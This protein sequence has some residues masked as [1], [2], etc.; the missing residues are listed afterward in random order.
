MK[1]CLIGCL[2]ACAVCL[3][4]F[5]QSKTEQYQTGQIISVDNLPRNSSVGGT[6]APLKTDVLDH[7]VSIQV[8]D[9]VYICRYHAHSSQE[10]SW[11]QGKQVQVR[12]KGKAMYVRSTAGMNAKVSIVRTT[13]ADQP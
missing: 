13:K 3:P 9:T 8:G 7:D 6:D 5:A 10:L 4:A 2:L 1:M 12:I 11:L